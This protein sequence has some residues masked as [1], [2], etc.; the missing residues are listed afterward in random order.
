MAFLKE[1][2]CK[3]KDIGTTKKT[4]LQ[5]GLSKNNIPLPIPTQSQGPGF[6]NFDS[7]AYCTAPK[8]L[9]HPIAEE[10]YPTEYF[11]K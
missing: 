5:A 11:G 10:G 3:Y 4:H 2:K 1:K 6:K 7:H 9:G 8:Q